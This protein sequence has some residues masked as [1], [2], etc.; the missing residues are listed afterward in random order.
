[1]PSV[2]EGLGPIALRIEDAWHQPDPSFERHCWKLGAFIVECAGDWPAGRRDALLREVAKRSR[3]RSRVI[4][5]FETLVEAYVLYRRFPNG[6][7]PLSWQHLRHLL[8]ISDAGQ[9][10]RYVEETLSRGWTENELGRRVDQKAL[11]NVAEAAPLWTSQLH[12]LVATTLA[13]GALYVVELVPTA[14]PDDPDSPRPA[15]V[16][17]I[18][19]SGVADEL[20]RIE[21]ISSPRV[22]FC[23]VAGGVVYATCESGLARL[24]PGGFSMAVVTK[25]RLA[26]APQVYRDGLVTVWGRATDAGPELRIGLLAGSECRWSPPIRGI[27]RGATVTDNTLFVRTD[28]PALVVEISLDSFRV[29]SEHRMNDMA[30]QDQPILA[31]GSQVVLPDVV[32]ILHDE[33][34]QEPTRPKSDTE[35]TIVAMRLHDRHFFVACLDRKGKPRR[36]WRVPE[37]I[38]SITVLPEGRG[39]VANGRRAVVALCP[40]HI[41]PVLLGRLPGEACG[42]PVVAGRRLCWL[43][44][45]E[46]SRALVRS[47]VEILDYET[48]TWSFVR[49]GVNG[50]PREMHE[51]CGTTLVVTD[52]QITAYRTEELLGVGVLNPPGVMSLP[53]LPSAPSPR[54]LVAGLPMVGP[55]S[56]RWSLAITEAN[57]AEYLTEA[58]AAAWRSADEAGRKRVWRRRVDEDVAAVERWPDAA[59]VLAEACPKGFLALTSVVANES[60]ETL[61]FGGIALTLDDVRPV[62]AWKRKTERDFTPVEASRLPVLPARVVLCAHLME[63]QTHNTVSDLLM[64]FRGREDGPGAVSPEAREVLA[65]LNL[66]RIRPSPWRGRLESVANRLIDAAGKPALA[67]GAAWILTKLV[68]GEFFGIVGDWVLIAAVVCGGL[69]ALGWVTL[70]VMGRWRGPDDT[71][72]FRQLAHKWS[73]GCP[74]LV[75]APVEF[76]SFVQE[77]V[78][79]NLLSAQ[80]RSRLARAVARAWAHPQVHRGA[81]VFISYSSKQAELASRLA[82]SLVDRSVEC[83]L[84]RYELEL[85]APDTTV[86]CW[87]AESLMRC[88]VLIHI[89]SDDIRH[90]GWVLRESEWQRR[91]LGVKGCLVMPYLIVT[92]RLEQVGEYPRSRVISGDD[93]IARWDAVVDHLAVRVTLD[94]LHGLST[95]LGQGSFGI[96]Y[97]GESPPISLVVPPSLSSTDAE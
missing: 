11:A 72:S 34:R 63:C 84:D 8:S 3:P 89:V 45:G 48:G 66:N 43:V 40:R 46:P 80:G 68:G 42:A 71:W 28:H 91:L 33:S 23:A 96:A 76:V 39:L 1:M 25:D 44:E 85:E 19:E 97:Q 94:W 92:G 14:E 30:S 62:L 78:A 51:S 54:E 67:L 2:D 6:V 35:V 95:A 70:F 50:R 12:R 20:G 7:P 9:R 36:E 79:G 52:R 21:W 59:R 75:E 65:W 47:S 57:A 55:V 26:V 58:E 38:E 83:V 60:A 31:R 4:V 56:E 29:V 18:D 17:R 32:D 77:C 27:A 37:P 22:G 69:W 10:A 15:R 81:M 87:I 61:S 16:L 93:L 24:G 41:R 49:L 53:A 5:H 82:A 73:S 88:H 86:Q 74:A 13:E 64:R 90:S